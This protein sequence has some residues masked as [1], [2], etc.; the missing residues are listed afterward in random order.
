MLGG[1][2]AEAQ[3]WGASETLTTMSY[4]TLQTLS[5][6]AVA[7]GIIMTGLADMVRITIKRKSTPK[8]KNIPS[9][10]SICAV[11]AFQSQK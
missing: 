2:A 9:L 6:I 10:W 4:H 11:E 3:R 7:V 1:L 8:R 5:Q